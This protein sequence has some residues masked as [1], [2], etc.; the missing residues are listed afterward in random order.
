[1]KTLICRIAIV[2]LSLLA[3]GLPAQ[4]SKKPANNYLGQTPPGEVP[5]VFARRRLDRPS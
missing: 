2:T 1:M 3:T 4:E 5:V